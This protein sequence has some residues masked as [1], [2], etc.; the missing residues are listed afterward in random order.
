MTR[1][2]SLLFA[3]LILVAGS[4][5]AAQT[6]DGRVD[7]ATEVLE[8]LT[9]IPEKGIPPSLLN[10]AYGVA[11][12]PNVVKAG[13]MIGGS[14][15]KGVLVVRRPDGSWS[16]PT[17]I[18][19]TAGSFG[20]QAGAQ[21]SDI[22]L[23]FKTRRGV[24]DLARGK[25]T[26]GGDVSIA[27]G[28]VGRDAA[29]ATDVTL[30][31]EIYSYSRS[32]GLFGGVSL[33]GAVLAMDKKAN[34]A[35]YDSN[36]GTAANILGDPTIPTPAGARRFKDVLAAAA[37]G[38]QFQSTGSRTA[39]AATSAPAVPT[40]RPAGGARTFGFDDAPAADSDTVF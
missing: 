10:N 2:V 35:Y 16:N 1:H 34:F 29:A 27:A 9:R 40:E 5:G 19:L 31:S 14:Y 12:V 20:F 21:S 32:R 18:S 17:F 36:Q 3:T 25:F 7:A 8:Q 13:F 6:L 37:P 23:V 15:G 26:L 39:S 33:E 28:P 30:K 24:D 38:L 22:V 4:A 11:V